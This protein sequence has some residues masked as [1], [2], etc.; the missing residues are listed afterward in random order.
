MDE[1]GE[2]KTSILGKKSVE[3]LSE[4][5]VIALQRLEFCVSYIQK[6]LKI[7]ASKDGNTV[8][9]SCRAIRFLGSRYRG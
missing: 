4:E 2:I 7:R 8:S 1:V 9:I 6:Q 3:T 5:E